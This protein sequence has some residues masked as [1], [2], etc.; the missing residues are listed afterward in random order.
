MIQ[1]FIIDKASIIIITSQRQGSSSY[2]WSPPPRQPLGTQKPELQSRHQEDLSIKSNFQREGR[3]TRQD[4]LLQKLKSCQPCKS[5]GVIS[6]VT[7]SIVLKQSLFFYAWSQSLVNTFYFVPISLSWC[8]RYIFVKSRLL[9][10]RWNSE[11]EDTMEEN[12]IIEDTGLIRN[13]IDHHFYFQI[14]STRRYKRTR[15]D[16]TITI[17]ELKLH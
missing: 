5:R 4:Y 7:A 9:E 17:D 12:E 6:I 11:I 14:K 10:S 16:I 2:T 15:G 8:K 3:T 1:Q 13:H